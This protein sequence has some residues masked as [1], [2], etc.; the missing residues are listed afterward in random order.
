MNEKTELFLKNKV[1]ENQLITA[2]KVE[3]SVFNR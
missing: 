2:K 1:E 3:Q